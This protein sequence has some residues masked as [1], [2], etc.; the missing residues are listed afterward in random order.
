[1]ACCRC[2]KAGRCGNCACVKAGRFCQNCLP[3][4][5]GKCV[6]STARPTMITSTP[7]A[8][9][10]PA[11]PPAPPPASLSPRPAIV[12]WQSSPTSVS[13]TTLSNDPLQPSGV[14]HQPNTLINSHQSTPSSNVVNFPPPLL[15]KGNFLW[16]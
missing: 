8:Q 10:D 12:S 16:G 14:Q 6:N 9:P 4:R 1:M 13:E 5:L 11:P 3:G 15:Q 2:N 7:A